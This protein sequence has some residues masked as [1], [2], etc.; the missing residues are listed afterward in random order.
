MLD[1]IIADALSE[2]ALS[3]TLNLRSS[4]HPRSTVFKQEVEV[5]KGDKLNNLPNFSFCLHRATADP[6]GCPEHRGE[7]RPSA[8]QSPGARCPAVAP[9]RLPA[10]PQEAEKQPLSDRGAPE[11]FADAPRQAAQPWAQTRHLWWQPVQQH[12]GGI[13]PA[14]D[15]D[16]PT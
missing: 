1:N 15:L 2:V 7:S 3:W 16:P 4:S 5:R 10:G 12:R 13:Q 8:L 14:G 6:E 11:R 9:S